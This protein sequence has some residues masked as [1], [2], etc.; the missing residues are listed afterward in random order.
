MKD[1]SFDGKSRRQEILQR[2][3]RYEKLSYQRLSEEFYVSRS[4]I[5]NDLVF[6]KRL[7]QEAGLK[8]SFDNSG[9]YFKGG[10][11]Q[12]QQVIKRLIL[13]LLKE[14]KTL[15]AYVDEPLLTDLISLLRDFLEEKKFIIDEN[16]ILNQSIGIAV[17]ISRAK[18]GYTIK[19]SPE[20][21]MKHLFDDV[22]QFPLALDFLQIL[23]NLGIYHFTTDEMEYIATLFIGGNLR[24]W[25]EDI[26][27]PLGFKNRISLLIKHV[28]EGLQEDLTGDEKLQKDLQFHL[29]QLLLRMKSQTTLLNPLT[30]DLKAQY[31]ILFG[32]VSFEM[33]DFFDMKQ[34]LSE[35]EI[36]FILIHFQ[37]A[38][39]RQ[40]SAKKILFVCPNG[41]GVSSYISAKLQRFLPNMSDFSVIAKSRLEEVDLE[42]TSFIIST[43]PLESMG[44]PVVEISPVITADDLKRIM[45]QYIDLILL[46]DKTR[47]EKEDFLTLLDSDLIRVYFMDFV[48]KKDV[49]HYLIH[50]QEQQLEGTAEDYLASVFSRENSQSTYLD[51]GF[52][53]PHGNPKLVKKSG[54]SIVILDQ[55]IIWGLDKA[56]VL[57]LLMVKEGDASLVGNV[58]KLVMRGIEDKQWFINKMLEVQHG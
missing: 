25:L 45:N 43:V 6:V 2:L 56:D 34:A 5:A 48:D 24:F 29:Y 30:E 19:V 1:I 40:K 49:L 38:I 33:A 28:S 55:P 54:V 15:E 46:E 13:R 4:S 21:E 22:N 31:P 52:A 14:E 39:E 32:F 3:F 58:V 8:L 27:L 57:I 53:I 50:Q 44:V 23:E 9:T 37:A 51:N 26:D 7:F 17:L 11:I 47:H 41:I 20:K 35:D 18:E 10:E 42:S 12:L 16:F 36:A